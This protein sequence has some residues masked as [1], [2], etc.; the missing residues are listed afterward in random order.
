MSQTQKINNPRN[1]K[2]NTSRI[3]EFGKSGT[4][5]SRDQRIRDSRIRK[6]ENQELRN[7]NLSNHG[8]RNSE[9]QELEK[10]DKATPGIQEI[11]QSR[12]Q[13][14]RKSGMQELRNNTHWTIQEI[15]N[16]THQAWGNEEIGISENPCIHPFIHLSIHPSSSSASLLGSSC[17]YLPQRPYIPDVPALINF[18]ELAWRGICFKI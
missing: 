7:Q 10:Q 9:N 14:M 11:R 3:Q 12:I 17:A 5:Q 6:S 18:L 13:G 2:I 1:L 4:K 15:K 8:F 16:L